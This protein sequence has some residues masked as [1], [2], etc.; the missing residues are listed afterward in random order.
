MS[1]PGAFAPAAARSTT[2][3]QR[4]RHVLEAEAHA[5]AHQLLA[6]RH[7]T[8]GKGRRSHPAVAPSA[9]GLTIANSRSKWGWIVPNTRSQMV[10]MIP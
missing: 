7:R 10:V 4:R 9:C 1:A 6:V 5:R 2:R 8:P 3:G